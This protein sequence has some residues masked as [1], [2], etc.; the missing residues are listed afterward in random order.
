MINFANSQYLLLLLLIPVFIILQVLVLRLR[1]NRI[2]KFGDERLV[3]QIMPSYSKTKTW[4]RLSFFLTGFFFFVI[5]L[6]RPQIGAALKEQETKGAEI[7]I[8]LDVSNSILPTGW[9]GQSWL[10]R[11]LSTNSARTA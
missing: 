11:V 5:G 9:N 2:R 1:R 10:Y 6:S 4:L 8:V 7:M 3:A